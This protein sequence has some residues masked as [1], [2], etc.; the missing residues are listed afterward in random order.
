MRPIGSA[1]PLRGSSTLRLQGPWEVHSIARMDRLPQ[2]SSPLQSSTRRC[3]HLVGAPLSRGF[4]AP[5]APPFRGEPPLPELPPPGHVASLPFLPAP[6][7]SSRHDLPGVF[8]P[9]ALSGFLPSEHDPAEIGRPSGFPS[10]PAI[11][12]AVHRKPCDRGRRNAGMQACARRGRSRPLSRPGRRFR[13]SIP[14]QDWG[15]RVRISPWTRRP[16]SPGLLPPWGFPLVRS[17]SAVHPPRFRVLEKCACAG[18]RRPSSHAVSG[19]SPVPGLFPML[20]SVKEPESRLASSEAAG[21][22]EVF[23]LVPRP[24]GCPGLAGVGPAVRPS[25]GF[26]RDNRCA[27]DTSKGEVLYQSFNPI[28][29][30]YDS[31]LIKIVKKKRELFLGQRLTS[32]CS[33]TLP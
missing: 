5:P 2:A 1:R 14:P 20:Q 27:P 26:S 30:Q 12:C 10:P 19:V 15:A 13:G 7:P 22:Y 29:I 9:G 31:R 23:V 32:P 4:V 24:P 17:R 28:S 11:R 3:P 21:P 16:G 18:G 6:T 8:Q 25:H 33:L